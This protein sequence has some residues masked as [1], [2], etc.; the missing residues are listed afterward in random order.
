MAVVGL[1]NWMVKAKLGRGE[2]IGLLARKMC[3]CCPC[4]MQTSGFGGIKAFCSSRKEIAGKRSLAGCCDIFLEP[5]GKHR[6]WTA[7]SF[8]ECR[9]HAPVK[10]LENLNFSNCILLS[11]KSINYNECK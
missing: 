1:M 10:H 7:C 6:G 8:F 11:T 5:T 3:P 2:L 4:G 9:K